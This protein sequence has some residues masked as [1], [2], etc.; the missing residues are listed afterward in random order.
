MKM[1]QLLAMLIKAESVLTHGDLLCKVTAASIL[2][3]CIATLEADIAKPVEFS[4]ESSVS[5]LR[6]SIPGAAGEIAAIHVD[7]HRYKLAPQEPAATGWMSI[8]TAPMDGEKF[9]GYKDGRMAEAYRVQRNDC[10]MWHFG[11]STAA[12]KHHPGIKPTHWMPLPAAPES[13]T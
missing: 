5:G 8:E 1:K 7:G 6:Y 13:T 4:F 9:L 11:N 10:E 2:R 12:V 3:G